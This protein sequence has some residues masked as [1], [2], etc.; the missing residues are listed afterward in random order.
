[1]KGW[2]NTSANMSRNT[3]FKAMLRQAMSR[4]QVLQGGLVGA[5]LVLAGGPAAVRGRWD[6]EAGMAVLGFQGI[7]VS[8]ADQ[9]VVPPG[10]TAQVL[11][12]WGDPV[13]DGP[14]FKLDGSHTAEEQIHQAGMHHD[15]IHF[16]PL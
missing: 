2:E 9:V 13:S 8:K 11:Y 5:G 14:V 7:P 10:Y 1:M 12:A 4:R 3:M 15:A 6:V 16:F